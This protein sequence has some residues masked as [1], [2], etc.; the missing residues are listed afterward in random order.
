MRIGHVEHD[1]IDGRGRAALPRGEAADKSHVFGA[2]EQ[3]ARRIVARMH[4]EI[5]GGDAPSERGF[6]IAAFAGAPP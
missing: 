4:Q 2:L 1:Q 3:F 6:G 5:G